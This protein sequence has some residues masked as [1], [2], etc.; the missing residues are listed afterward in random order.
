MQQ[1][2]GVGDDATTQTITM[3]FSD[4]NKNSGVYGCNSPYTRGSNQPTS[5]ITNDV[6]GQVTGDLLAGLNFGYVGSTQNFKG[7]TI[8]S[9]SSTEWWG[10]TM[11]D[12]TVIDPGATPGGTDVYFN[13]VQ[14]DSRDYNSYSGSI[15]TLTF[16]YGFPLQD[17][18]GKNLLTMN[19]SS[20]PD[21]YLMV[22]VD[23]QPT[24]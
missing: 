3:T 21:G 6:W 24:A 14:N 10:G 2:P 9:L 7:Q 11:P 22:W 23:M 19:T 16:G 12:G 15:S 18:L 13:N 5:G 4:L 1:G 8:G 20:D 17:R